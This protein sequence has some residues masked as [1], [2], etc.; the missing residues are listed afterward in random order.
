MVG[1]IQSALSKLHS[2]QGRFK[3]GYSLNDRVNFEIG[4]SRYLFI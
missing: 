3:V 2:E 4:L 1:Y